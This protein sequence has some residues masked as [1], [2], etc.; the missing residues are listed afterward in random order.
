MFQNLTTDQIKKIEIPEI[1]IN[2]QKTIVEIL[3]Q[4]ENLIKQRKESIDLLDEFLKSTFLEMFG[5]PVKNERGWDE[6]GLKKCTSKI[7]SGATPRGVRKCMNQR[8]FL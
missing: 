6:L 4:A 3:T 5:D 2:N 7:G 1:S 8:V